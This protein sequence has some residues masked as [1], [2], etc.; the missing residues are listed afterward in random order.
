MEED[1]IFTQVQER[2][3]MKRKTQEKMEIGSGK[4]S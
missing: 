2:N 4:R 3:K 1:R